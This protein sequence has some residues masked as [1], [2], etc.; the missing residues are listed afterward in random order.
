M[1]THNVNTLI[2]SS[3]CATYGE[4]DK[5]P[6]TEETPQVPLIYVDYIFFFLMQNELSLFI[7]VVLLHILAPHQP[8]WKSQEDGR[9]YYPGF[10]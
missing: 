7:L 1:A 9:R 2:Y 10:P 3:T 5:M 8:L 4:P 6:I